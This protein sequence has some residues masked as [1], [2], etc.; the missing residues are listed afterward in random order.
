MKTKNITRVAVVLAA[1][2][3][4]A[5]LAPAAEIVSN[6][7]EAI[8]QVGSCSMAPADC[9]IETHEQ[10]LPWLVSPPETASNSKTYRAFCSTSNA[11]NGNDGNWYS[12]AIYLPP[13]YDMPDNSDIEYPV[14]YWL[15]GTLD[16][17]LGWF[18]RGTNVATAVNKRILQRKMT[19]TIYVFPYGGV[20]KAQGEFNW[21]DQWT[22]GYLPD[23]HPGCDPDDPDLC[24]RADTA[25]DELMRHV[26]THYRVIP[27]SAARGIQGFSRG[28]GYAVQRGFRPFE[29]EYQFDSIVGLSP[30]MYWESSH[31]EIDAKYLAADYASVFPVDEDRSLNLMLKYGDL[32]LDQS[33]IPALEFSEF[34]L[35]DLTARRRSGLGGEP[36]S[37]SVEHVLPECG[38]ERAYPPPCSPSEQPPVLAH[39]QPRMKNLRGDEVMRFHQAAFQGLS[40]EQ[41]DLINSHRLPCAEKLGFITDPAVINGVNEAYFVGDWDGDGCE[42]VSVVHNGTVYTENDFDSS[43]DGSAV[44]GRTDVEYMGI[45]WFDTGE[46]KLATADYDTGDC[47]KSWEIRFWVEDRDGDGHDEKDEPFFCFED[48]PEDTDFVVG[49]FD[50]DW[51]DDIA[52]RKK[53]DFFWTPFLASGHDG[54]ITG[55]TRFGKKTGEDQYA[56]GKW[57][58]GQESAALAIRRGNSLLLNGDLDGAHD[59]DF[60]FGGKKEDQYLFGDWDGDGLKNVAARR[61]NQF[62]LDVSFDGKHDYQFYYGWGTPGDCE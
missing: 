42:S 20:Y 4:V 3:A 49:D 34:L 25:F 8:T 54:T 28:G 47:P 50:G 10:N 15:H 33:A 18:G 13:G 43:W 31:F 19:P 41:L 45:D 40:T 6:C 23:D 57:I 32:D 5:G 27:E 29:G 48:A 53:N 56:A 51:R 1:L 17:P 46:D 22:D 11:S 9:W 62:L 14:V 2:L 52:Y 12:Y 55:S 44:V 35:G 39:D 59:F 30:G 37:H 16:D 38:E 21:I 60:V 24:F 58:A 7:S 61:C 26:E 36:I